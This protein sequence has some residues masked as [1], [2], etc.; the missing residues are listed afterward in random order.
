[1]TIL[2]EAVVADI[3]VLWAEPVTPSA[4]KLVIWLPGF[5]GSKEGVRN[6]L[7][8]LAS[9]GFVGMSFD[10]CQHGVRRIESVEALRARVR[11]NIRRY[12]WPIL[13]Q[14]AEETPQIIDWAVRTL[15][16]AP[17]AGMGGISMGG[18]IAV[19]A[20]GVD[21][22]IQAVV[23]GIATADWL[24]PGSFEPPGEPNAVAQACYDQRNPLTHLELYRH[25]PAISFQ[26]GAQDR[27]VPPDG[28]Q[29]FVAALHAIYA[30]QPERL[31]VFCQPDTPHKFTEVM[32]Q[33]GLRWFAS[34]L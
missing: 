29:R 26:C 10:P 28:A 3:P 6:N 20:A 15:G 17:L 32:W 33:N 16:V 8:D 7:L 27:Q 4:R 19:A 14:T 1:M 13:A 34:N 11:G 18:D 24:R 2:K 31:E 25:R 5:S 12:F 23:A 21:Q 22:R 30:E 9:A